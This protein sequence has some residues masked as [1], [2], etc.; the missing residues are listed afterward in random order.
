MSV[1][2]IFF[3]FLL[4][5]PGGYTQNSFKK[6]CN[7]EDIVS[8]QFD[9][10]KYNNNPSKFKYNY[11]YQ[12][13]LNDTD[14]L[15]LYIDNRVCN[16]FTKNY[17]K[18]AF[19]YNDNHYKIKDVIVDTLDVYNNNINLCNELD[20]DV[21][22]YENSCLVKELDDYTTTTSTTLAA[23]T[24]T[25]GQTTTTPGQTTTTLA[26]TTTTLAATT[27]TLAATTTTPGQTTTTLAA[28]TTTPGQTNTSLSTEL[29][30]TTNVKSNEQPQTQES[31]QKTNKSLTSGEIVGI[32][33]GIVVGLV[34]VGIVIVRNQKTKEGVY[35]TNE[36]IS[37]VEEKIS[38]H[39]Y[40]YAD[41]NQSPVYD[42]NVPSSCNVYESDE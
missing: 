4:C 28:T 11:I 21:I 5:I 42:N 20:D 9:V 15:N 24:T 14:S 3:L 13:G 7:F 18:T 39:D 36:P 10:L 16:Y 38:N 12:D 19:V 30:N 31:S 27:T 29:D 40:E 17:K 1:K 26:A 25:P 33:V 2:N 35:Y 6:Q 41:S 37:P 8:T 32:I 34:L 22:L 23:T